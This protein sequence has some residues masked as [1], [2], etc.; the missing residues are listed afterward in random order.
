MQLAGVFPLACANSYAGWLAHD[1]CH[2][3]DR[4]CNAMRQ[5][6][7]LAAGLGTIMWGEKH[8]LHHA[9]TNVVGQDEDIMSDPFF[10]LWAPDPARDSKWRRLQHLYALPVYSV[11]FALWR[12]NSARTV[13]SKR[14]WREAV[15]MGLNYLRV[16]LE[17]A[18]VLVPSN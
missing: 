18:C 8:N 12:F 15:P 1:Y 17:A 5:F 9:V 6:G 7:A 14:L 2:G 13:W 11:L 10:Y 16:A 4:F 3:T